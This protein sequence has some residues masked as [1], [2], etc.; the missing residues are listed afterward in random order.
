M[1]LFSIIIGA[2]YRAI[3][4]KEKYEIW[5]GFGVFLS[6]ASNF[7]KTL[8]KYSFEEYLAIDKNPEEYIYTQGKS[9]FSPTGSIDNELGWSFILSLILKEDTKGV[10]NLA[11]IIVRWQIMLDLI[12]IILLFWIGRETAGWIG[13][14][15]ASFLY[16]IFKMPMVVASW[17]VYY[18]W[19][20]PFSAL[21]LFFWTFVY[22][23]EKDSTKRKYIYFFLYGLLMGFAT[24]IRLYFIFLP[25]LLSPIVFIRE[26][27]FKKATTLI[28]L[29]F[30]GQMLLL[31]PQVLLNKKNHDQYT[32]STRGTW[33]TVI[34]GLGAYQNPWGI[35]DTGDITVVNWVIARGGPDL[36]KEGMRAYDKFCKQTV[37]A[38]FRE[39]PEI[40]IKN[41]LNNIKAGMTISPHFFNFLGFS[42]KALNYDKVNKIFPWL[43]VS[44]F[45]MLFA[46]SRKHF[47]VFFI[48]FIHGIY[49]MFVVLLY[50]PNYIP[51]MASYIPIFILL[52]ATCIATYIKLII[53]IVEAILQC[54]IGKKNIKILPWLVINSYANDW[55]NRMGDMRNNQEINS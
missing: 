51:F 12:V 23:A 6:L 15:L 13:A 37:F 5:N 8:G 3:V 47:W 55:S 32:L 49:F 4:L 10:N 33:H 9:K 24:F 50:F 17:I 48:I 54:W 31:T 7:H 30:L 53:S 22:K 14:C 16:A 2:G 45:F 26:K 19:T 40:F 34:Q 52:F 43:I 39:H 25:L 35:K 1:L 36:N 44:V 41:A 27:K 11:L 20:I 21:S 18:Y 28:L 29:M 42:D 38:L 46:I